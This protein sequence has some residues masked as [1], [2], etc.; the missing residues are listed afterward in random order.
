MSERRLFS[1]KITESDAFLDMPLSSQA[2][3]FHLGLNADDYGVVSSPKRVMR[4][5]GSQPDDLN[6]LAAKRFVLQLSQS[7]IV[8]K[9][10]FTNNTIRKDRLKV[11]KYASLLEQLYFNANGDYTDDPNTG[12]RRCLTIDNQL[13][14]NGQP[15]VGLTQLNSTQHNITQYNIT[16][17]KS[18]SII[19]ILSDDEYARL[20]MRITDMMVLLDQLETVDLESVKKPY[21]YCL[22]VAKNMGIYKEV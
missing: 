7:V 2:L 22:K 17:Y 21:E 16:Q 18:S 4:M 5:V 9:H 19:D 12:V 6:I 1:T 14:T 15:M 13:S 3:Y 10:W 11:S 20:E 8:I